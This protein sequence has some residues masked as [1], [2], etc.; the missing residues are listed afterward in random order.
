MPGLNT[1]VTTTTKEEVKLKPAVRARLVK[2]LRVYAD[3]RDQLKVIEAAMDKH[4]AEIGK[5]RDE[6]G[7]TALAIEGFKVTQVSN[8]RTT[9]DKKKLIEMGVTTEMLE[10][11]TTT[12]PGRPY[13]KITCPGQK[14]LDLED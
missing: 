2:S 4:K 5:I 13:E 7:V 6:A 12:K 14:D 11:A 1:T 3:L 10:E 9:L 8:L